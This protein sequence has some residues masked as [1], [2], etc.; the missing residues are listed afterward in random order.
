[1][2][3]YIVG[4]KEY[5]NQLKA[6]RG[7]AGEAGHAGRL[8][9]SHAVP[10]RGRRAWSIDYTYRVKLKGKYPQFLYWLAMPF[11]A[12]VPVEAD[13]FFAQPGMAQK[14]LTLDW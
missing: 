1:M 11:F 4:L 8:D 6:A 3:E 14:N 10:A 5:A 7:G 9:R 2:A 12:P 13:R